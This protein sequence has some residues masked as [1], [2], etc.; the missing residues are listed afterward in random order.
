MSKMTNAQLQAE[1]EEARATIEAL[2]NRAPRARYSTGLWPNQNRRT[3]RDPA[4]QGTVRMIVPPDA[5]A[6]DPLWID[7]S[8][9]QYDAETSPVQYAS[10]PPALT[11]S[12]SPC[13]ADRAAELEARRIKALGERA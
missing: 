6:G 5:V 9:W 3:D 12:V 13:P 8:L 4:W 2:K 11:Q 10:N 1:L 7:L